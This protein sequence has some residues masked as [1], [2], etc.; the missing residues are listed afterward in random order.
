VSVAEHLGI[1]LDEYDAKIRTFI[2]DY[3]EMIDAGAAALR[4]LD[5]P[6]PRVVD[7]G[8]GTGA[9]AAACVRIVPGLS[10]TG[11]DSDNG[12]LDIAR[13]RLEPLGITATFI[14]GSFADVT[15]PASD[16]IVASFALHHIKDPGDKRTFF[17]VLHHVVDKGG[18][19][20]FVDCYPSADAALARLEHDAWRA[21]LQ[22][23][24]S[25]SEAD[26]LLAAWAGEDTYVAL[27]DEMAMIQTAGFTPHIV[28]RRNAFAVITARA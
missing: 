4:A 28:W 14:H 7:L 9:F 22:R 1:R 13:S 23:S 11:I 8:I 21:H 24:Y 12:I 5:K 2:P 26:S 20:V 10:V 27:P 15:L 17:R 19:L 16:A 6:A 25:E 3:E 18:L